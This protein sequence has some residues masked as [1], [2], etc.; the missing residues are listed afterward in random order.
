MKDRPECLIGIALVESCRHFFWQV[1]RETLFLFRPL[2]KNRLTLS[3]FF[4]S[5]IS[6]PTDPVPAVL[7]SRGF[8]ALARPP[9]LRSVSQPCSVFRK[10]SGSRFETTM[11]RAPAPGFLALRLGI[12]RRLMIRSLAHT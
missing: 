1:Y 6:G 5:A 9:E 2:G 12:S 11:S 10:V 3:T 7:R 8:I 4:L